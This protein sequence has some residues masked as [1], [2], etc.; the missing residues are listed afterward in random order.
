MS[1]FSTSHRRR[2]KRRSC[3]SPPPE[4]SAL[5]NSHDVRDIET[6]TTAIMFRDN[7][8]AVGDDDEGAGPRGEGNISTHRRRSLHSPTPPLTLPRSALGMYIP[9]MHIDPTPSFDPPS[10]R[11]DTEA[12][13][14]SSPPPLLHPISPPRHRSQPTKPKTSLLVF[15]LF[16]RPSFLTL[17]FYKHRSLRG[18]HI[19]STPNAALRH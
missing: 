19:C 12:L 14:T 18:R 6:E 17:L 1:L 3:P 13:K 4:Y 5:F 10:A 2:R 16:V 11:S 8:E 7:S 15:P 9:H